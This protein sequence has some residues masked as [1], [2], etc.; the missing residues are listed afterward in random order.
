MSGLTP[1]ARALLDA[2][3]END[4]PSAARRE[5]ARQRLAQSLAVGVSGAVAVSSASVPAVAAGLGAAPTA[6]AKLSLKLVCVWLSLGAAAGVAVIVPVTALNGFSR[7]RPPPQVSSSSVESLPRRTVLPSRS[8]SSAP[9]SA[10][11]RP[12]SS[13]KAALGPVS[14]GATR[15]PSARESSSRA[16]TIGV[17]PKVD[18][19][20]VGEHD[21]SSETQLLESVQ[22]RLAAG[23]PLAALTLLDE[24]ERHFGDGVLSDER[25]AARVVAL[26]ALGRSGEAS[27]VLEELMRSAPRSPLIPRLLASCATS[28]NGVR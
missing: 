13:S 24:H 20:Q 12:P 28:R 4:G 5:R 11:P 21:L 8:V 16:A 3:G 2:V 22:R 25:R 1:E 9:A 23:D 26:C 17:G 27:V 14:K 10:V 19:P 18:A 6:V 15:T 7:A